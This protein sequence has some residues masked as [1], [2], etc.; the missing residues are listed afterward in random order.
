MTQTTQ[1]IK[2]KGLSIAFAKPNLSQTYIFAFYQ[3][4]LYLTT[5]L[6]GGGTWSK[7]SYLKGHF[8]FI[9]LDL[10]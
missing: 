9:K 5:S 2:F 1:I 7:G 3:Y 8:V 6:E 10:N 4:R